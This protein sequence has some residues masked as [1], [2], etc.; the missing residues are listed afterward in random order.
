MGFNKEVKEIMPSER[1]YTIRGQNPAATTHQRI[2]LS[3]YDPKAQYA[4]VEFKIMPA[5]TPLNCDQYGILTMGADNNTDP[6][7]PDFS[8]Q[9]QIA[10]AHHTVRQPVPPGLGESTI[11]SNYEVNDEKLF[12]YDIHLHTEDTKAANAVNWFLKIRRY[13]VSDVAGSVASLRQFQYNNPGT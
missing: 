5:G 13:Y 8:N 3:S 1:I 2:Q 12:A 9:N 10:W 7:D 4:I 11:I 6:S